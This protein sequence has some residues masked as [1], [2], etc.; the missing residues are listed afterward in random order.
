MN[1]MKKDIIIESSRNTEKISGAI[2]SMLEIGVNIIDESYEYTKGIS[3][4]KRISYNS[5]RKMKLKINSNS[6]S[7]SNFIYTNSF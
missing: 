4:S 6:Y 5:S 7:E 2:A 1:W 3:D